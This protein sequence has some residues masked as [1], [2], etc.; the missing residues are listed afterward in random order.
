MPYS[1]DGKL[2]VLRKYHGKELVLA[3]D[4]LFLFQPLDQ[5]VLNPDA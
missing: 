5:V 3:E 2:P 4:K 1:N